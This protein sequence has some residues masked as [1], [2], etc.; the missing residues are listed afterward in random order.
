MFCNPKTQTKKGLIL[1]NT[2][3]G[4]TSLKKH[5]KVNYSIIAKMFENEVNNPLR[6]K[7][8]K[9]I[10]KKRS[11]LASSAIFNVFAAKNP[12]IKYHMQQKLIFE[13]MGLLIVKNHIPIQ[14][15]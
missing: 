8:E 2:T 6:G 5:V 7:L 10:C 1:Y 12:F 13:D 9:K 14:F 15:V 11:N 4:I 3:N